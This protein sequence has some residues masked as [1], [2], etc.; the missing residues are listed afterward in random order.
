VIT[1]M[2]R[3][4][5][6]AGFTLIEVVGALLVFSVGTL[7]VMR[8]SSALTTQARYAGVRS[9]IVVLAD[10]RVDSLETLPFASLTAGTTDDTVM[11][12]GWAYERTVIVTLIT[13]VLAKV[14]VALQPTD[15]I[16]PSHSITSYTSDVW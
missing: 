8:V 12:T 3:S 15:G 5:R 7:M 13:P 6:T 16:G 1:R 11:V 14:E 10:E 9:E 4:S 2:P